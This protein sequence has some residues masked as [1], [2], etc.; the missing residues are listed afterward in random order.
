MPEAVYK[1]VAKTGKWL[2]KS[3]KELIF[4]LITIGGDSVLVLSAPFSPASVNTLQK[5]P[6]TSPPLNTLL[7][8][9]VPSPA[10]HPLLTAPPTPLDV[11]TM[12]TDPLP[13]P[14]VHPLLMLSIQLCQLLFLLLP[15]IH[16]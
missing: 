1:F 6:P 10:V 9:P 4:Q 3:S 5:A 7:P 15:S 11:N 13:H 2:L 12:Q 8:A 16:Y 14:T